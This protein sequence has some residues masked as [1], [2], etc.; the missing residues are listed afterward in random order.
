MSSFG[1]LHVRDFIGSKRRSYFQTLEK[2]LQINRNFFPLVIMKTRYLSLV[3]IA[4]IF[5]MVMIV[6]SDIS[7]TTDDAKAKEVKD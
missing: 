6:P 5:S 3:I 7:Q 4:I 2:Y 1:K